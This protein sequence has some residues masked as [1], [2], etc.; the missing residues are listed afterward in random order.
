MV[1]VW[2]A[3]DGGHLSTHRGGQ[4]EGV[5]LAF[6]DVNTSAKL[7][8]KSPEVPLTTGLL[9]DR[10]GTRVYDFNS[11]FLQ[12]LQKLQCLHPFC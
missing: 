11:I 1:L 10:H 8:I 7:S 6:R 2:G 4:K 9:G 3:P 12:Q 5:S